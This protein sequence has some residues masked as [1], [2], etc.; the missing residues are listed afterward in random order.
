VSG[1]VY[2]YFKYGSTVVYYISKKRVFETCHS[3]ILQT[4][5]QR[6]ARQF[7]VL[8]YLVLYYKWLEILWGRSTRYCFDVAND[9]PRYLGWQQRK[10]CSTGTST[11]TGS[12]TGTVFCIRQIGK[13]QTQIQQTHKTIDKLHQGTTLT[14]HII[15][16]NNNNNNCE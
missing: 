12:V 9:R 15:D 11:D 6:F 2:F 13:T 8:L 7:F 16:N 10:W 14:S 1:G 3:L 5:S 4:A